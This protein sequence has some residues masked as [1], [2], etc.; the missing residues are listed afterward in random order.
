MSQRCVR[1]TL[2]CRC[3][4]FHW[5]EF[6]IDCRCLF[7]KSHTCGWSLCQFTTVGA[8]CMFSPLPRFHFK[9]WNQSL[10][11]VKFCLYWEVICC[12]IS[13]YIS[14]FWN[15]I[16][17]KKNSC[18]PKKFLLVFRFLS[19]VYKVSRVE[20][21]YL[22]IFKHLTPRVAQ[23]VSRSKKNFHISFLMF[24]LWIFFPKFPKIFLMISSLKPNSIFIHFIDAKFCKRISNGMSQI[25]VSMPK[26]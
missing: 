16:I 18:W 22:S 14:L 3:L 2:V 26:F 21:I 5:S 9:W 10:I 24:L 19:T 11:R 6:F 15:I 7:L 12:S 25:T 23:K 4:W 8:P 20:F 1:W 17:L 13:V